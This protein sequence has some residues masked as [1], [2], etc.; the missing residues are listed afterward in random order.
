MIRTQ[1]QLTEEQD[2]ALEALASSQDESKAALVRRAVDLLLRQQGEADRAARRA[3]ALAVV[4][5]VRG[6]GAPVSVEHDRFLA[7]AY[8]GASADRAER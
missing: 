7:D 4:G 3:R 2:R 6:D 5:L 8:A 1:I